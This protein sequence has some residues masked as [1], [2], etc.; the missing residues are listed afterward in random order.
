M[1]YKPYMTGVVLGKAL[2]HSK[3]LAHILCFC[4]VTENTELNRLAPHGMSELL[5][6]KRI[7][8]LQLFMA[9]T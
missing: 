9:I 7:Y 1:G 3:H 8:C 2:D 4:P 5:Q 6:T